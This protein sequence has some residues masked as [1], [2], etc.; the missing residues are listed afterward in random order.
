MTRLIGWVGFDLLVALMSSVWS[1]S[2]DSEPCRAWPLIWTAL[3]ALALLSN[4]IAQRFTTF[5]DDDF[6]TRRLLPGRPPPG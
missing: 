6:T 4:I 2:A 1:P 3:P 5:A